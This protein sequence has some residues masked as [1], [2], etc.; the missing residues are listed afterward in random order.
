MIRRPPRSTLFPYTTLFRSARVREPRGQ[1]RPPV[2]GRYVHGAGVR[3]GVDYAHL[4]VPRRRGREV[5]LVDLGGEGGVGDEAYGRDGVGPSGGQLH[6]RVYDR[7]R[8]VA[9]G[10]DGHLL[11]ARRQRQVA[12]DGAVGDVGELGDRLAVDV[13][14]HVGGVRREVRHPHLG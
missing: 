5:V 6:G 4:G 3:G 9:G 14:A 11:G 2:G 12:R 8:G 13:D 1:V 10:V 7:R